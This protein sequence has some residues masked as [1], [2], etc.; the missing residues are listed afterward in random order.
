MCRNESAREALEAVVVIK[1]EKK[2]NSNTSTIGNTQKP[3]SANG[4]TLSISLDRPSSLI[5]SLAVGGKMSSSMIR[6]H[7]PADGAIRS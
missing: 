3:D 5:Y 7:R 4:S 2:K 6:K 1:I